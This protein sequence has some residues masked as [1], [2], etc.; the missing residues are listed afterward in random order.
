[1]TLRHPLCHCSHLMYFL[2][3]GGSSLQGR[4]GAAGG[5]LEQKSWTAFVFYK[6]SNWLRTSSS[7]LL[8]TYS[9][10]LR[11]TCSVLFPDPSPT[12]RGSGKRFFERWIVSVLSWVKQIPLSLIWYGL[13]PA[14][15]CLF[16]AV[17]TCLLPARRMDLLDLWPNQMSA[18]KNYIPWADTAVEA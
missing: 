4:S 3:R 5:I 7:L 14:R 17:V 6:C 10:I 8:P 1:M 15:P 18:V 2:G 16:P 9:L 13:L 11:M 12:G